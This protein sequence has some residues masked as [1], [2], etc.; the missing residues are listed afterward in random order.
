MA[1]DLFAAAAREALAGQAPLAARLRPRRLDDI[2]GQEDLLGPGR[3]L[4]TL[5]EADRLSSVVLWG[6]PGTG[7]TTLAQAIAAHTAKA[8]EQLSAVSAGV[9][10]VRELLARAEQRLGER[11]QGTILFLDEVHRFN[12]SQQDALLPGVESG[13]VTLIGATTENPFFEVNPP[14]LSRSTLFRLRPLSDD[15]ARHLVARGLE[16]EGATATD[17]AV[18]HL[19]DHAAGD[20]RHVLTS[21]EVAVALARARAEPAGPGATTVVALA[22]AEAALGTKALR[23]GRDDHYDV[24][25]AFIKSIRGSDPQAALHWLARMLEAGEDARFIARRLVILASEDVGLADPTGLLVAT[26]AAQAVEHVGLPEA[27][28]NLAQATVHLAT[29]PKSNRVAVGIWS[30]REDVRHVAAGEVPAHLRDAHYRGAA[31]LGHGEGYDYPHDHPEGWVAQQYLPDELLGR[32][33][34]E[35]STHGFEQEI[36]TR[37]AATPDDEQ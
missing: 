13:L 8:F 32:V 12:K 23:Y 2:V 16:V 5:I 14:L 37:M 9:K 18:A 11:G 36:R 25:S 31:S 1:D 20:G 24:V 26:A 35:P 27:Q 6:P 28:L 33:Y 17:D 34:Y 3:P 22:D 30:A 10:D 7:K 19:V 4:R 21:L 29:A 15:A